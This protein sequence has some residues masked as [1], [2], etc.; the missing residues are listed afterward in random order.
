MT[1]VTRLEA[2]SKGLRL[3]FTGNPC[4]RGHIAERLVSSWNC[5]E[6]VGEYKKTDTFKKVKQLSD[7]KY[8]K[9]NL[10]KCRNYDRKYRKDNS[11][12]VRAHWK[13]WEERNPEKVAEHIRKQNARPEVKARKK[14]L[15]HKR[16][17]IENSA[18]AESIDFGVVWNNS[19]GLC[20]L[21]G[22]FVDKGREHYDHVIPLSRGGDHTYANV[23]VTHSKCNLTKST[24]TAIEYW[25]HLTKIDKANDFQL[26]L[27]NN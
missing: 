1:T 27:L 10:E 15:K 2:K 8:R 17:A 3:Y 26:H 21:C 4:K 22:N 7:S 24:R 6:C 23:K 11:T 19:A 25:K 13:A 16:R 14:A 18:H 12:R 5:V 9:S 20:F